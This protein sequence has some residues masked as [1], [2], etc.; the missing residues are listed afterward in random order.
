MAEVTNLQIQG[1][2]VVLPLE[3]YLE[4]KRQIDDYQR[5][6]IIYER[7]REARFQQLFQI[8]ERNQNFSSEEI[9]TEISTAINAIRSS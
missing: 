3:E 9:D 1:P 6:K 7:Q 8:A 2:I 5:L 4:I